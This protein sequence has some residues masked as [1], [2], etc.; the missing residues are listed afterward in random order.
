MTD[1]YGGPNVAPGMKP[2][3]RRALGRTAV[4]NGPTRL[5]ISPRRSGKRV[6][7]PGYR[8]GPGENDTSVPQLGNLDKPPQT[9]PP[10]PT[11]RG[12]QRDVAARPT[13]LPMPP[14]ASTSPWVRPLGLPTR[15]R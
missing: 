9:T 1:P 3:R 5:P 4:K 15:K 7:Q 11:G 10:R 12:G 2:G 6:P 8:W 13:R 14:T